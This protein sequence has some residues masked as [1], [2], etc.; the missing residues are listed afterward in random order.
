MTQSSEPSE[1]QA[2]LQRLVGRSAWGTTL[3]VGSFVTME[4]GSE[5]GPPL[6]DGRRHGEFH[7]WIYCS[8]WRLE[9]QDALL[10]ASEDGRTD[11]ETALSRLDGAMVTRVVVEWPSLS[12]SL[13]LD[14][15]LRLRTFSIFSRD[16]EHWHLYTPDGR[17][18]TAG[19]G[20][21]WS[22]DDVSP[23]GRMPGSAP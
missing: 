7:L 3:G 22:V 20:S 11:M 9:L 16:Y 2:V 17:A 12:L 19:P 14:G 1:L 5:S 6:R 18:Y 8:A 23:L 15:G 4:F 10:A 13:E 21:E